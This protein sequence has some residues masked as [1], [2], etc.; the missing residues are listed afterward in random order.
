MTETPPA[1]ISGDALA[2]VAGYSALAGLCPL[3]PIPFVDDFIIERIHRRLCWVLFNQ[4]GSQ[5][6]DAGAKALSN[7]PSN[8]FG[9]VFRTLIFWP[10]KKLITKLVY[11]LAVKSCADVA[12]TVFNEGWLLARALEQKYVPVDLDV[13]ALESLRTAIIK[14][15]EAVDP[16]PTQAA[17]RSAFGVGQEVFSATLSSVRKVLKGAAK[18]DRLDAAEQEVAPIAHRIQAEIL[19]HWNSG[20]QLDAELKKA[21]N[22]SD[23]RP[24]AP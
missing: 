4:H 10:I 15:R 24:I 17:M 20:P 12:S 13:A 7:S 11:V 9:G 21:L 16:S 19:K 23:A 3:I 1:A 14:A 2:T 6:S 5:L 18:D 8:L 22:I